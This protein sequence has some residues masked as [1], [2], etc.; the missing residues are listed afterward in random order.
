MPWVIHCHWTKLVAAIVLQPRDRGPFL[1]EVA[2]TLATLP[3]IGD[4]A[5]HRVIMAVQSKHWDPP[6]T[7]IIK[8]HPKK[9]F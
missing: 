3:D 7:A 8:S 1:E 9:R 6:P 5:L 2:R 4:G